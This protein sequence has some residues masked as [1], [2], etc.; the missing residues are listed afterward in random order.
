M[1]NILDFG[2]IGNGKTDCSQGIQKAID[3]AAKTQESVYVPGG[4]FLCKNIKMRPRVEL[5]GDAGWCFRENGGSVLQLAD[6]NA[7]CILDITEA[8]GCT[9]NGLSFEGGGLGEGINGIQTKRE[10]F[11]EH[12]DAF[13][14]E[15]CRVN[16]FSGD[17]CHFEKIWCVT[18]RHNMLSHSKGHGLSWEGWDGFVMDN[19]LSGNLGAGFYAGEW[20]TAVTFTG[21]RVEWNDMG[22]IYI[23]A[24]AA[25]NIANCY[26]DRHGGPAIYFA[27]E[28]GYS[29]AT[30]SVV[31]CI[32]GQEVVFQDVVNVV[33][34]SNI[35]GIA[36]EYR[37]RETRPY[38]VAISGLSN[39]IIKDNVYGGGK[40]KGFLKDDGAHKGG[41]I[42]KD[43]TGEPMLIY[44]R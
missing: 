4:V 31:G 14:I 37:G 43:N 15:R 13:R 35:F 40:L 27:S 16:N 30:I 5:K 20:I 9:I 33:C 23:K 29:S 28:N 3:T 2:A 18:V 21:N 44:K 38:A 42:I 7:Q 32:L 41:V 25:V 8:R 24:G 17:S 12:E 22:G 26:F 1:Y 11:P 34:N 6:K 36:D 10:S 39:A 19:W